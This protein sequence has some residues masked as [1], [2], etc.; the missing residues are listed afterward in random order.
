MGSSEVI[1]K[2]SSWR[3]I[4]NSISNENDIGLVMTMGNLHAGHS[5]LLKRSVQE[6]DITVLTIFVN[7][8]QFNDKNDLKNYPRTEDADI[9]LAKSVGVDFILLFNVDEL[10]P[11]NYMYKIDVSSDISKIMEGDRRPGHFNGMLTIVVKMHCLVLPDRSYFG[12]KD[13][14]QYVL[15]RDA[16]EAFLIQTKVIPCEIVRS[17][18]KL[19]L[20][21]RNNRL[22]EK[23]L[24]HA[25]V[26]PKIL[27]NANL[28]DKQAAEILEQKGFKVD[29]INSFDGRRF[30]AVFLE[31]IR[32]IDN[33]KLK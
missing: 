32:L 30:G 18:T 5:S 20:S 12:E 24:A 26:F 10:Y 3:K 7:P 9:A 1:R 31:N 4:R 15:V 19:A 13:Y 8:A 27:A 17:N 2:I 25:D 16:L 33:I 28:S 6:N 14:Q 22:S 29:Y 21:S 11:D 23:G